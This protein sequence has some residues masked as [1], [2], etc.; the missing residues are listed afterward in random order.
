ALGTPILGDG[1]YGG[2]AAFLP[3]LES[4]RRLH[5]HAREIR[6]PAAGRS[7][8]GGAHP[9]GELRITAPL[10]PHMRET[11]RFFGFARE[12]DGGPFD[13]IPPG[14]VVGDA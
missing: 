13:E 11:W 10:P 3:G 7:R 12:E 5:L 4:A 6:L 1:K 2:R 14:G 8:S 9:K